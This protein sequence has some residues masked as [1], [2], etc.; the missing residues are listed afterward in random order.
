MVS[1]GSY[2]SIALGVKIIPNDHRID[3]VT[4]HPIA[5]LRRYG[6]T[7]KDFMFDYITDENRKIF[8]GNDVWIGAD[9]I[10]FEGVT[11][12]DGAIIAAGS[13]VRKNV[14]PYAIVG[15]V[16]KILK[17]R[18]DDV[19]IKKLLELKW[20]EWEGNEIRQNIR[21]FHN[22]KDFVDEFCI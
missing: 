17:Y 5:S 2:C 6:M 11:I 14:P 20:W 9:C 18:F 3:W 21:F 19:T 10:I 13:I 22:I 15:G 4:T 1:V 8:I 7:S 16:D 12:G